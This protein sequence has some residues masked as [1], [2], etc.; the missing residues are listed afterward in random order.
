MSNID[1]ASNRSLVIRAAILI[2][3]AVVIIVALTAD[4]IVQYTGSSTQICTVND[5]DRTTDRDGNSNA[6][7][8]TDQCGV[9]WVKDR[10]FAGHVDSA[11]VYA[12]IQVGKTYELHTVGHRVPLMSAFPNITSATEVTE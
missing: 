1:N 4:F 6:R 2:V 5:K 7:V 12:Q 9:F 10:L 11:D 3:T 8:Y